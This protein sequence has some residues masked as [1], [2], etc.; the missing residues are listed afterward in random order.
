[1]LALVLLPAMIGLSVLAEQAVAVVYGPQ[2]EAAVPVVRVLGPVAALQALACITAS[3]M[4]AK[5]RSDWLYRWTLA[6]CLIAAG[7]MAVG[8]KWGLIGVS[9]ALAAVVAVLKPFE[10]RMALGL[11]DM[12]LT[13]YARTLLPHALITAAMAMTAW[14]VAYGVA[15]LGGGSLEQLL[16]GTAAGGMVHLGLVWRCR[17]PA[18]DD[19]RRVLGQ[20]AVRK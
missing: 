5:G 6:N 2:W 20:W 13:T 1:V 7:A 14:L 10:I 4:L 18:L 8:A 16:A 19:A 15:Q 17:I 3:V 9:L 12:R 11:I